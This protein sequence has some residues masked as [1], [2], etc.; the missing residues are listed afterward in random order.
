MVRAPHR[1]SL[2]FYKLTPWLAGQNAHYYI[3]NPGYNKSSSLLHRYP[4]KQHIELIVDL[5]FSR[6]RDDGT[7]GL[8]RLAEDGRHSIVIK[9]P[10]PRSAHGAAVHWLFVIEIYYCV[11]I[12]INP[13]LPYL[14]SVHIFRDELHKTS[15]E[16]TKQY[17][18][19]DSLAW[20]VD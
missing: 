4:R 15:T 1:L 5:D 13:I 18:C 9:R 6:G 2:S 8:A 7:E 19:S 12:K 17:L 20:L 11:E 3:A 10:V 16:L 14:C